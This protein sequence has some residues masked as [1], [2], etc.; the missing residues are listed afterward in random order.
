MAEAQRY[1]PI[2]T[3]NRLGSMGMP[4]KVIVD[5]QAVFLCCAGCKSRALADPQATLAKVEELKR[6]ASESAD[7]VAQDALPRDA[8][9][10][11]AG[12]SQ[13]LAGEPADFDFRPRHLRPGRRGDFRRPGQALARRP[14]ACRGTTIL[15]RVGRQPPGLDGRARKVMVDGQPVFICCEGCQ[16]DALAKPAETLAKVKQLKERHNPAK[17]K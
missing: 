4:L 12:I 17:V 7:A 3:E 14:A 1:C 13:D 9:D 15:R 6:T 2:L 5:G 10:Q 11:S 16:S 8:S